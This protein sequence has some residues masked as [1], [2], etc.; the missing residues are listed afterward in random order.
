ML[1]QNFAIHDGA[2][3]TRHAAPGPC[4]LGQGLLRFYGY[5]IKFFPGHCLQLI[6]L[7]GFQTG[8]FQHRGAQFLGISLVS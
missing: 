7:S 4:F 1:G 5:D 8:F 2:E 3:S 6:Q